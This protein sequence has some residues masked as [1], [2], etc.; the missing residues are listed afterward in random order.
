M[1]TEAKDAIDEVLKKPSGRMA[2]QAMY[3]SGPS[4]LFNVALPFAAFQ[5]L[6]HEHVSTVVA[7][8]AVA[9]FPLAAILY[10]WARTRRADALSLIVLFF[11]V[12]GIASSVV[13][14][15][16]RF[17][18]VK[19]SLLTGVFGLVFLASLLRGRP[20]AFYFGRQ[21]ATQGEKARMA[22]WDSLWQYPG[23]RYS[24]RVITLVWGIG[25]ILDAAI[26]VLLVFVLSVTAFMIVS[27]ILF[28]A[29][30]IALF[31]W[32]MAYARRKSRET[33]DTLTQDAAGMTA[34]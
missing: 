26:R 25:W 12:V 22:Y 29:V 21:F 32:T 18:L 24:Q 30:F 3:G 33:D 17:L 20:L 1:S 19:E 14:G 13:T 16:A 5:A 27:Q 15:D 10:G 34:P 6:S 23:F 9:V 2:L 11:I 7:L 8:S 4:F 28:F 31:M